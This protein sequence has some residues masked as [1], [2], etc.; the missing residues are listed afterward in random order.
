MKRLITSPRNLVLVAVLAV[1]AA[2]CAVPTAHAAPA[3]ETVV[4]AAPSNL[5]ATAVSP[6]SVRLTWTN[7]AANQSGVVISLDGVDSVD[8]Q[9]ATVSSYTGDGLS[10]GTKYWFYV[11]SKI[12]GTPGDPTGYGNTQSA[13]VGPAYATTPN[14]PSSWSYQAGSYAGKS[15]MVSVGTYIEPPGAKYFNYCG[16]GAS[17][18][19]ISGWTKSVPSIYTLA[20]QE[21]TGRYSGTLASNMPTPINNSIGQDYYSDQG[22]ASTQGILSDRIGYDILHGHPLI[23]GIM[24]GEG[25]ISL[26]DWGKYNKKNGPVPH[27][28]TI[29]GFDFTSPSQGIIYYMETSN[30]DAGPTANGP[31]KIDYQSFWALVQANN[32]QVAGSSGAS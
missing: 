26:N 23:T 4:P 29:Y 25:N 5:T 14:T 11:A 9:G 17:Q 13:W 10:P 24:T 1:V 15:G 31:M 12:Y 6:D 27:I 16:P 22:A 19:L 28:I 3:S 32:V 7:N 18:V 2:M 8:V 20:A 21:H 30:T